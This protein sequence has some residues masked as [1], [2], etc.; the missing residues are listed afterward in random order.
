MNNYLCS[1]NLKQ[2]MGLIKHLSYILAFWVLLLSTAP[3]FL[4]DECLFRC[5]N[6]ETE[7]SC[8][9]DEGSACTDCCCS[10]FLHCNTCTG[11]PVPKIFHS[12]S[13]VL[14]QLNDNLS[15]YKERLIPHFSSSI[16][17]PPKIMNLI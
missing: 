5:G 4:K 8:S 11:C 1:R 16:W 9:H 3:C 14:I 13:I 6:E 15:F 2:S 12:P 7:E 10:P 17:Q